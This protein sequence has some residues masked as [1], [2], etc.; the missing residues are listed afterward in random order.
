MKYLFSNTIECW[1]LLGSI[2]MIVQMLIGGSM[3]LF[4]AGF[5]AF[6]VALGMRFE[7]LALNSPSEQVVAF[8]VFLCFWFIIL[9][10]PLGY[11]MNLEKKKDD[12]FRKNKIT[13]K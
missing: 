12:N 13:N 6:S 8:F 1:Y 3:F 9:V 11:L 2:I 5:A 7:L 10:K 4:F